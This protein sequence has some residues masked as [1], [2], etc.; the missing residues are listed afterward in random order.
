MLSGPYGMTGPAASRLHGSV[1]AP[2]LNR[3]AVPAFPAD[4]VETDGHQ[5][6]HVQRV[7]SSG[8]PGREH[9]Q[10]PRSGVGGTCR[11][12]AGVAPSLAG[13]AHEVLRGG[14][15]VDVVQCD[16]A[17]FRP[18]CAVA[19]RLH[20]HHFPLACVAFTRLSSPRRNTGRPVPPARFQNARL[21]RAAP[22]RSFPS[23]FARVGLTAC[24]H[25]G[26]Q[27][28]DHTRDP[29]LHTQACQL[30]YTQRGANR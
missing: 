6:R 24:A 16:D 5:R 12:N 21:P 29:A 30:K 13:T 25:N 28:L 7:L 27:G 8:P 17:P 20:C 23:W 26:A 15:L 14:A 9:D 1:P 10:E 22:E 3:P 18:A 4:G 19:L 2:W 11:R